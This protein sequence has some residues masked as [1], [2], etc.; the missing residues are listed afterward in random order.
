MG[1]W[2]Y[3]ERKLIHFWVDY[4]KAY[5]QYNYTPK[6]FRI[7]L[8]ANSN[9]FF[10]DDDTYIEL[11]SKDIYTN[12]ER[13]FLIKDKKTNNN[14]AFLIIPK[15]WK[16]GAINYNNIFE[17]TWQGLILRNLKFYFDF[18][19]WAWFEIEKFKRVDICF[20]MAID[21]QYIYDTIVNKYIKWKTI[22]PIIKKGKLET[23]YIWERDTRKNTYQLIRIY[24]KIL[25]TKTKH[26]EFLYD[27]GGLES[28]TRFEI[29]LRRD[30]AQFLTPKKL[31]DDNYIFSIIVKNFYKMNYQFFKFLH[32]EDFKKIRDNEDS[33]YQKRKNDIIKRQ[34]DFIKF[35]KDFKNDTDK[36]RTLKVFVNSAKRLY[37]N[38]V[39]RKNLL[40]ILSKHG[41]K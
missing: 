6:I 31:L 29:E 18:I 37:K 14:L 40:H 17:L 39:N 34:I 2:R 41:I 23:L 20:D 30:K 16:V 3:K 25:D 8:S 21:I 26:K 38:G 10:Y 32:L 13:Y 15:V 12:F 11:W 7:W 36:Q 9:L 4:F 5:I 19:K 1:Y 28:L 35:G 27:F 22:Q 24:D 33:L